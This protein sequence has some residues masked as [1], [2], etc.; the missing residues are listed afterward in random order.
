MSKFGLGLDFV[1]QKA[2]EFSGLDLGAGQKQY[3]AA[4]E[5]SIANSKEQITV[6]DGEIN[7]ILNRTKAQNEAANQFTSTVIN[8]T[9]TAIEEQKKIT[10]EG[11][12][13]YLTK[14]NKKSKATVDT[15]T[16]TI[17][18]LKLLQ[19]AE[20]ERQ[21]SAEQ[22]T[23]LGKQLLADESYQF[24]VDNLGREEALRELARAEE[25]AKTAG[26]N[27]AKLSLNAAYYKAQQNQIFFQKKWEDQT[28]K[29]R[30]ANFQSTLGAISALTAS[31][32]AELFE[33]GK[34]AAIGQATIDGIAA[35]QKAYASAPPPFGFAL[36]A[37]V[38]VAT[39]ANVAKIASQKRPKFAQ[40]G[41]VGG[42]S[43][44][45]DKIT[46]QL[47]SREMVLTQSQQ[48]T[49]FNMANNGGSGNGMIEAIE[50]LGQKIQNMTLIVQADGRE[51]AKLVRDQKQAGFV[52]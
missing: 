25:L 47:N 27:A 11:Q 43:T 2:Q 49:L 19:Q 41:I 3:V 36:A 32:N 39:A 17:E 50:R 16:Q 5:A 52:L 12:N 42:T 9:K 37:L 22:N 23:A 13:D 4:Q 18:A 40:G 21:K 38:G 31:S 28:N 35:V 1:L 8:A 6:I 33:I 48:A 45:G 20:I 10:D 26:A 44:S 29:E 46:A 34:A 14:L 51:I 24:L 30:L 7:A 15:E